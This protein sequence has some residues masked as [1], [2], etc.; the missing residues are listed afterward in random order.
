M[1]DRIDSELD[2][3]RT[4][5]PEL[6]YRSE[7]RWVRVPMYPLPPGWSRTKTDIAFQIP[8]QYPGNPPYGFYVPSGLTFNGQ[9]PNNCTD[10][11]TPPFGGNW[12]IFSWQPD[13]GW[14]PTV[15]LRSGHNLLNWVIGFRQ[16]FVEGI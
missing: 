6:E 9:R 5:Y 4:R 11:N 8:A 12:M 14:I 13:G 16:R 10:N 1:R 3:L 2:L 7:G 15:D